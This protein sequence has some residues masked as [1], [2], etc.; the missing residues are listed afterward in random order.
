MVIANW[1][2][3]GE[4]SPK[5]ILLI[6]MDVDCGMNVGRRIETAIFKH[7]KYEGTVTRLLNEVNDN[8]SD[9]V[10]TLKRLC[11]LINASVGFEQMTNCN[12]VRYAVHSIQLVVVKVLSFANNS[13]EALRNAL[14]KIC[15]NKLMRQ[16]YRLEAAADS[17]KSKEP[18]HEDS[19]TRWNF[20]YEMKVDA[21]EN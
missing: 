2:D 3:I 5:S 18:T 19:M 1:I 4:L 6:I 14:V 21:F 10:A 16:Q 7:L 20:T 9:V 13:I 15:C 8:D 17:T 11:Q 12:H